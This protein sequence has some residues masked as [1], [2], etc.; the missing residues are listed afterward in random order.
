MKPLAKRAINVVKTGQIKIVPKRFEKVYFHWLENIRDW[1]I[2][3]QVVWGIRIP[4]WHCKDCNKWTVTSGATPKKCEYCDSTKISQ[5]QDNFDTWFSSSQWPFVSLGYPNSEDY[6]YFYPT[7][8]METGYDILFFWV[9]RM[10]MLGTHI[11]GKIPFE[12]VY[13]HGLVRD[14]KGQKMS[15]SKGNVINPMDVIEKYGADALRMSLVSSVAPGN[16]QNFS[17]AKLIGFRNFTNKIWNATRFATTFNGNGKSNPKF[18]SWL[19]GVIKT[20]NKNLEEFKI[21]LAAEYLYNE[22]WHTFCDVQI[23]EAKKGNLSKEQLQ[24]GLET[25]LKL[26]HPFMPF[27]T[28]AIWQ[29]NNFGGL[30]ATSSFPKS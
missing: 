20:V 13:L 24:K 4:A 16:D 6:K 10:V 11:T 8:V 23:E 14:P 2:A 1:N 21:G 18:D 3:R 25:F 12:V 26:L 19:T 9:A 28:E 22:F 17:D 27:I 29:E 30:L 15:K 5:D 7:S